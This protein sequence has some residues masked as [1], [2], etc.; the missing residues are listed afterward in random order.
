MIIGIERY[1]LRATA[2][3]FQHQLK[4]ADAALAE[5]FTAGNTHLVS[6]YERRFAVPTFVSTLAKTV[7][8]IAP[9]FG[10]GAIEAKTSPTAA[11]W[12]AGP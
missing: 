1:C 2:I 12:I 11:R 5:T 4:P 6:S 7:C 10:I 3:Y 9:I 8:S